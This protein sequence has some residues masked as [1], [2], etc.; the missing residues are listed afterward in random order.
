MY[1]NVYICVCSDLVGTT[2]ASFGTGFFIMH[3]FVNSEMCVHSAFTYKSPSYFEL[4]SDNT[5]NL[6]SNVQHDLFSVF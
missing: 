4:E 1:N 5:S 6:D 3:V 2:N